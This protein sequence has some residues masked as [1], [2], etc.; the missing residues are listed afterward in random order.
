MLYFNF[1][2]VKEFVARKN[3]AEFTNQIERIK[4]TLKSVRR[5][6]ARI[7]SAE[8]RQFVKNVQKRMF[9]VSGAVT[10]IRAELTENSEQYTHLQI[11]DPKQVSRAHLIVVGEGVYYLNKV[12]LDSTKWELREV[13]NVQQVIK[14][15]EQKQN[16]CKM[17]EKAYAKEQLPEWAKNPRQYVAALISEFKQVEE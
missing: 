4:S 2:N 8:R 17:A 10:A 1:S 11:I 9:S 7:K 12:T 6:E 14:S 13:T 16:L 3:E 15:L 5:K